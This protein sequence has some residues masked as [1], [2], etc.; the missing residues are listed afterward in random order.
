M[1]QT[2]VDAHGRVN[3]EGLARDR[4]LLDGFVGQLS[5]RG[6]DSAPSQCAE[7]ERVLAYHLNAYKALAMFKVLDANVPSTLFG[8][9]KVQFLVFNRVVV[10]GS[11]RAVSLRE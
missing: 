7:R 2:W 9:R 5:T 10:D 8:W 3:F 11:A 1:L 6:P 4:A